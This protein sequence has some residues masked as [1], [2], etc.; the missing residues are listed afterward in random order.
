VHN[1]FHRLLKF[2]TTI[3][4]GDFNIPMRMKHKTAYY[5]MLSFPVFENSGEIA[6]GYIF[7]AVKRFSCSNYRFVNDK[8]INIVGGAARETD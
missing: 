5:G 7:Q 4:T 1:F 8:V 3:R 2:H 6:N